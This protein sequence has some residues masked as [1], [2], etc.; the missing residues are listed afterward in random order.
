MHV[1]CNI[2]VYIYIYICV[3][4]CVYLSG[5]REVDLGPLAPEEDRA[6]VH[7]GRQAV[8]RPLHPG[9][10]L[11][12]LVMFSLFA[13]LCLLFYAICCASPKS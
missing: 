6:V 2:C 5:R 1:E 13:F 11:I 8:E 10:V 3:F 4:V 9:V 12:A 7:A